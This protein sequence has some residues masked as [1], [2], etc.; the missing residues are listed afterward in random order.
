MSKCFPNFGV[1]AF[2]FKIG[3]KY[4][5][6]IAGCLHC[7]ETPRIALCK[8]TPLSSMKIATPDPGLKFNP[9]C[10][11]VSVQTLLFHLTSKLQKPKLLY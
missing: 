3:A 6:W 2:I 8:K 4:I 5:Y 10:V 7:Y 9:L 1:K 11:L